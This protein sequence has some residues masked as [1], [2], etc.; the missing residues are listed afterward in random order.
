MPLTRLFSLYK[1]T[2]SA[3]HNLCDTLQPPPNTDKLLW[4][5]LKFCI[6]KPLPKPRLDTTFQRLEN[7]IRLRHFWSTRMT[8]TANDY[9]PKLY[10]KSNWTPD[11]ASPELEAAMQDFRTQVTYMATHNTANQHRKHNIP[12]RTRALLRT[13]PGNPNFIILPTDKNL[14][15][16]I[17][18]RD[19]YKTRCLT[20][21]LSDDTTY[22]RLTED[23]AYQRLKQAEVHFKEMIEHYQHILPES[24][25]TYFQR[26]FKESRRIPQFYCTPKVHKQPWK[27][28]PIVSCVNSR[29]GDLSKWVDVQ[30][31]RVVQ[32]CP[33]YLKDSQSLLHRLKKLGRLPRK[34]FLTTADAVSMY[35]NIDTPH[36]LETLSKW[37]QLHH[38]ELPPDFPT[39]MVLDATELVMTNNVIQFDDTFWLQLTGTAMG[40]SL[41]CIYATIYYSYH[42]ETRIYPSF[43]LQRNDVC[44]LPTPEPLTPV[45]VITHTSPLI[46]HARLID[47]AIQIWDAEQLPTT[48]LDDFTTI[49][50]KILQFGTLTWEVNP[51]SRVIDFLDLTIQITPEGYITT[52]TFVKPMNLHL[53][54]PPHSAHPPGVL[55]SLIFGNIIRYWNQNTNRED[56][57]QA[58]CDFYR[59]LLNR[60]YSPEKLTPIFHDAAMSIDTKL[61]RTAK[62]RETTPEP[63][64]DDTRDSL[65]IHWEYHPRDLS[66]RAIRQAFMT[67]LMPAINDSTLSINRVTI[68]YSTP[69]SLGQC[70]TKTQ[71]REPPGKRVSQLLR[72]STTSSQP[73]TDSH[74]G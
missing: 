73:L 61:I 60:G 15:P 29:M 32:L 5:G 69:R 40:T 47:D 17:M 20:D 67:T 2:Q 1:N 23:E 13:L 30:L 49:M 56:F 12:T 71:L 24:E 3:Y 4:N 62:W 34:A 46:L 14:G 72:S 21:H 45:P 70:L 57:V 52:K 27:T 7:D 65:F 44:P 10:I 55:K 36:G 6:E 9:N 51:P 35:T 26:C 28:R 25:K 53:Y 54:I 42:E 16:S 22:Q 33:G 66:R 68:A 58:S 8:D 43:A 39:E 63:L 48:T 31:Q 64:D 19:T 18:E 50:G 41:A 37:F 38:H 11:E 59:H 74:V